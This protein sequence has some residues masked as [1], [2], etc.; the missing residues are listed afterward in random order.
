MHTNGKSEELALHMNCFGKREL[1]IIAASKT[2]ENGDNLHKIEKFGSKCNMDLCWQ[3]LSFPMK[4]Y[5][6]S[7]MSTFWQLELKLHGLMNTFGCS[8]RHFLITLSAQAMYL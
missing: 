6:H 3:T 7:T 5:Y 8:E 2:W 1:M 4:T